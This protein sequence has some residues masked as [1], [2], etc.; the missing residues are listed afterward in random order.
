M[1]EEGGHLTLIQLKRLP[2]SKIAIMRLYEQW[3]SDRK[4]ATHF[5]KQRARNFTGAN[6]F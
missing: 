3:Q 5:S 2:S 4:Q 1:R 6:F